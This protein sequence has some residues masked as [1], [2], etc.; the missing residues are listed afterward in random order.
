MLLTSSQRNQENMEN[1]VSIIIN[2][3]RYDAVNVGVD[4]GGCENCDLNKWCC[5]CDFDF[6][7]G[8]LYYS[9][10][11]FKKSTKSFEP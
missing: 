11:V 5:S 2:G 4:N 8:V 6:T 9:N 1:Q 3:V 7:C 10:T